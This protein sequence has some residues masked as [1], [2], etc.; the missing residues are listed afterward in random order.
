M[1]IAWTAAYGCIIWKAWKDKS[2]GVPF[3]GVCLNIAWEFLFAFDVLDSRLHWFFRV[4][5]GFWFVFD[6]LI[7]LQLWRHG[8][9]AQVLEP[10][11]N[12]FHVIMVG[13]MVAAP[14]AFWSFTGYFH[15]VK[16]VASS[17]GL[18]LLLS[19]LYI[20]MLINR[21]DL[22]GLSYPAAWL[23]MIGSVTGAVFVY[24]WWPAQFKDG[25]LITH[26][27]IS[28]P[29]TNSFMMFL[30]CGIFILDCIYIRLFAQRLRQ[31]KSQPASKNGTAPQA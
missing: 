21:P 28:Q 31:L 1:Y 6:I 10:I 15:D 14:V 25:H 7:F 4:G 22:R 2:Y 5:N 30:Y 24:F 29:T 17:F 11:R 13:L 27:D 20:F 19:A 18:N 26:P 16:G 23:K 12:N 3:L 8:R 9:E